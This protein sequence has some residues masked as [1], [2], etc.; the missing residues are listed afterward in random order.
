M[1]LC[2]SCVHDT[3]LRRDYVIER[4][5]HGVWTSVTGCAN[6]IHITGKGYCVLHDSEMYG[7]TVAF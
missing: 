6:R 5:Y 7:K 4:A 1:M 3:N 2:S